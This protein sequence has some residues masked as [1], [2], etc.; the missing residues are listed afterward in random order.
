MMENEVTKSVTSLIDVQDNFN[1]VYEFVSET[2][3]RVRELTT[4]LQTGDPNEKPMPE[5]AVDGV[6]EMLKGAQLRQPS[7]PVLDDLSNRINAVYSKLQVIA[8]NMHYLR[9]VIIGK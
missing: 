7:T 6:E 2:E 8:E 1:R 3:L 4:Y 5:G 9:T